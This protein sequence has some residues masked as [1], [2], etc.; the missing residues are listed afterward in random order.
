MKVARTVVFIFLLVVGSYVMAQPHQDAEPVG[1]VVFTAGDAFLQSAS[2]E[3][4]T[5]AAGTP[6]YVGTTLSTAANAHMHVQMM[7]GALLMLRPESSIRLAYYTVDLVNPGNTKILLD[8]EKGVVRSV[9]GKGGQANKQGFRLNTP[10]AAI[11]IRGTDFTVLASQSISSVSLQAGGII[12]SP[13]SSLCPRYTVGACGGTEAVMLTASDQQML[14]EVRED[15]A[16]RVPKVNA[17]LVPDQI[18]PAHPAE[19]K[20]LQESRGGAS[21]NVPDVRQK[22]PAKTDAGGSQSTASTGGS[23]V[24]ASASNASSPTS[25]LD[26]SSST[27][28]TDSGNKDTN[29]NNVAG[30]AQIKL[31]SSSGEFLSQ[32][33][34]AEVAPLSPVTA[35]VGP[36]ESVTSE[37]VSRVITEKTL[38][39]NVKTL[40]GE[41]EGQGN[42]IV[43]PSPAVPPVKTEPVQPQPFY[44]GRW[45]RYAG[46]PEQAIALDRAKSRQIFATNRVYLLADAEEGAP[47]LPKSGKVS[48][49]LDKW[50]AS[51]LK[52]GDLTPVTV[53]DASLDADFDQNRFKTGMRISSSTLDDGSL[54]LHAEGGLSPEKGTFQSESASSNMSVSGAFSNNANHAAYV[55]HDVE[56]DIFGV[57]SWK[58][59]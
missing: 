50:D 4:S 26:A 10:V 56:S 51:V 41:M 46:T 53:S 13:F 12:V 31:V 2:G 42:S 6:I 24:P 22:E 35:E 21:V 38:D 33:A 27:A 54:M 36:K 7:D 44:W 52:N 59:K 20:S 58:Q 15:K 47:Q 3:K 23:A 39:D 57:T 43:P 18:A 16:V 17:A 11:G 28:S 48:F 25:K 40:V 1:K 37:L 9:T 19:E 14:A 5:G 34:T 49:D 55:F 29:S 45:A 8:M 30:A 32:G